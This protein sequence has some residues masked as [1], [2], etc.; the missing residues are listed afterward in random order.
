MD[1]GSA[2]LWEQWVEAVYDGSARYLGLYN[3][4]HDDLWPGY[5]AWL[6]LRSGHDSLL[7][8]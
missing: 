1:Y 6:R 2:R 5:V 3:G 7:V 8:V 4:H